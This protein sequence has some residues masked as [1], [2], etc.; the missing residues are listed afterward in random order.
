MKKLLFSFTCLLL[1]VT[2]ANTAHAASVTVTPPVGSI[3]VSPTKAPTINNA[4]KEKL[5]A[6]IN[7]LK[8]KIAS[9]VSELKLVEKRGVIGTVSEVSAIKITISDTAGRTRFVDVDEITKFA[10]AS[11]KTSFG[12][13]DLTKGTRISVLGIY[14]KQSKRILARFIDVIVSPNI[15]T[16]AISEIDRQGFTITIT[17]EDQKKVK[18]DVET[19]TK[20]SSYNKD[21]G[22]SKYGF[23]KVEVGDRVSVVGYPNKK[24]PKLFIATRIIIY[25]NLP[26]NPRIIIARPTIEEPEVT[27]ATGSGKKLTP[28]KR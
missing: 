10:S 7:D 19:A 9:R 18:M 25:T 1:F 13:S 6:Q 28:I 27:P 24:D 5:D 21:D 26:K 16:G 3:T 4:V 2:F 12:L 17:T 15:F 8:E 11:S 20:I 23:S 22:L 14:N